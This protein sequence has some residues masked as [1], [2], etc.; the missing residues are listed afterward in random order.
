MQDYLIQLQQHIMVPERIPYAVAAILLVS[1]LG[2][3]TGPVGYL[4]QPALFALH[5]ILWG[6]MGDRLDKTLRPSGDLVFRGFLLTAFVL[7]LTYVLAQGVDIVVVTYPDYGILEVLALSLCLAS[8]SVWAITFHIK[9]SLQKKVSHKNAFLSLSRSSRLDLNSTDDFGITRAVLGFLAISFDKGMVAPVFWYIFGGLPVLFVYSALSFLAWRF[10]KS[11]FTKGLG[12]VPLA[13]EKLMGY[14]PS[15]LAGF[16]MTAA[17]ALTPTAKMHKSILAWW[18]AKDKAPYEEGGIAVSAMAW[19]LGIVI[20]GP[21]MDLTGSSL[22][23]AWVGPP[24]ATAQV[25]YNHIRRALYLSIVA[26]L[27]YVFILL[28]AYIYAEKMF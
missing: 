12:A 23:R 2:F 7:L 5:N 27:L 11:G 8:G 14:I 9:S 28:C 26:H 18:G 17:S 16:I 21:V 10:G 22:Q 20:G 15:L 25:D 19:P 3:I 24:G 4:G 6:R 13:L 1:V